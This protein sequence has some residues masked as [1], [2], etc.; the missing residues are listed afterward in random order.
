MEKEKDDSGGRKRDTP[1]GVFI[2]NG[3]RG[4]VEGAIFVVAVVR[5]M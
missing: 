3:S 4:S 2:C 1:R 5:V